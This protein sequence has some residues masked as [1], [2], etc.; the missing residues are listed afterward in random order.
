MEA[1]LHIAT[2]CPSENKLGSGHLSTTCNL[3]IFKW[4]SNE[5]L[6]ALELVVIL[7]IGG[8]H[9]FKISSNFQEAGCNILIWVSWRWYQGNW[10]L[11]SWGHYG[12]VWILLIVENWKH[13]SKIIFK[14]VTSIVRPN[15]KV[16]FVKKK[17]KKS[18]CGS[19]AQC[20][21]PTKKR[22]MLDALSKQSLHVKWCFYTE[23]PINL[24]SCCFRPMHF[25][26]WLALIILLCF[27]LSPF[28]LINTL[29]LLT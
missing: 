20:T 12:F 6:Y 5:C 13:Y 8:I 29:E 1:T 2:S 19:P 7:V 28:W 23:L 16:V 22:W 27:L 25:G 11:I 3:Y 14:F 4:L 18:N 15:F 10:H 26:F 24:I 17:K 21:G 9:L